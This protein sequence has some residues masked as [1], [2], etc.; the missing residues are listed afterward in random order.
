MTMEGLKYVESVELSSMD[1]SGIT[2]LWETQSLLV[3]RAT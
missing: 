2:A 3:N 1:G